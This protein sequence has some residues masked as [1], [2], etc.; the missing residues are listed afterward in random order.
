MIGADR[1]GLHYVLSTVASFSLV[2][3]F[4]FWL[5]SRFTFGAPLS[6]RNLGVF[7]LGVAAGFP[8]SLLAMTILCSGLQLP[9]MV[10]API[11]TVVLL[12]W[13]YLSARFAITARGPRLFLG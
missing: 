13:N 9:V 8:L 12:A 4:G 7:A 2:T 11:A 1:L 10:A 5:H 3:P 6:W